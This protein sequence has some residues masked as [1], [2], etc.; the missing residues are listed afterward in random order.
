MSVVELQFEYRPS[1]TL[2]S[3]ARTSVLLRVSLRNRAL[4]VE[5]GAAHELKPSPFPSSIRVRY[6]VRIPI[7]PLYLSLFVL[8]IRTSPLRRISDFHRI[9]IGKEEMS[10]VLV[11]SK[12]GSVVRIWGVRV[13]R[14]EGEWVS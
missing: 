10:C 11:D 13:K 5:K 9:P 14:D 2:Y 8:L 6:S 3:S 7:F 4:G 12:D 1:S